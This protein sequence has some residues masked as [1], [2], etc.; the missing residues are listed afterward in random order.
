MSVS[1]ALV[2]SV[3]KRVPGRRIP[4]SELNTIPLTGLARKILRAAQILD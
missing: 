4:V 2:A 1:I 3:G